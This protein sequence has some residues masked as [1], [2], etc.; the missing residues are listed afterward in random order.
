MITMNADFAE[1]V[2]ILSAAPLDMAGAAGLA[3]PWVSLKL[4]KRATFVL[5][6]AAGGAAEQPTITL[7]QATAVAGTGAKS[8][9]AIRRPFLKQHATALEGIGAFTSVTQAAAATYAVPAVA[10]NQAASMVVFDILDE[11][12]DVAGGFDCVRA[13]VADVGVTAKLGVLFV[14]LWG[15]A[16]APPLSAVVD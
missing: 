7:Q 4:Y 8:L 16:Y 9:V 3:T 13:T 1:Q 14:L 12:L 11:D 6:C 10:G 2:N 5:I 15:S